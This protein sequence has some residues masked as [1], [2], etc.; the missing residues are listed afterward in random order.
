M[1]IIIEGVDGCGKSVLSK[2][3]CKTF[4]AK[5]RHISKPKTNNPF[6]EY[7]KTLS[8]LSVKK[9]Y[10]FDRCFHGER[11]YG[12]RFRG[13]DGLSDEKQLFL[14]NMIMKHNPVLI[15][16]WQSHNDIA[17]VY[18]NRGERFTKLEDVPTLEKLYRSTIQKSIIPHKGYRWTT[19]SYEMIKAWIYEKSLNQDIPG[20]KESYSKTKLVK[21]AVKNTKKA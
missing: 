7:V 20:I 9:N 4:N 6:E 12:P 15:Y 1:I 8:R 16:C 2:K 3:L 14:E 11:A 13:I 18:V 21:K 17:A 10:V 5:Y 19:D